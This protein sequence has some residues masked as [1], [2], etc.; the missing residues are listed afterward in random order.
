M[1]RAKCSQ[2][3]PQRGY[4]RNPEYLEAKSRRL[5]L[6]MRPSL[7]ARLKEYADGNN[8]SVNEVVSF[9]VEDGLDR[10]GSRK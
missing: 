2:P 6:L 5:T 7:Y 1:E 4:Y 10:R 8:A 9:L 3:H